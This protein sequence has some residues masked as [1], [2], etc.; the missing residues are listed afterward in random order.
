VASVNAKRL[1]TATGLGTATITATPAGL[2]GKSKTV[3]VN[4]TRTDGTDDVT[5]RALVIGLFP[6]PKPRY[7]PF[8]V[9]ST[10]IVRNA[11]YSSRST[12]NAIR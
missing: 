8:S 4:V 11:L 12:A 9:N 2:S 10:R 7:L 6:T 3:T 1:V 5:Y